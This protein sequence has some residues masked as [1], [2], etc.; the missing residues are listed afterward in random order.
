M[1]PLILFA[2]AL[3]CYFAGRYFARLSVGESIDS[4]LG[5]SLLA[6]GLWLIAI[7]SVVWSLAGTIRVVLK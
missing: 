4:G 5:D 6:A 7:I 3:I 1:K 2:I